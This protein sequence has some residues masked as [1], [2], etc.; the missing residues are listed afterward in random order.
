M[1]PSR[2]ASG[3][4]LGLSIVKEL[5]SVLG[6]AI[7]IRSAPDVGTVVDVTLPVEIAE[8]TQ[9]SPANLPAATKAKSRILKFP[10]QL[11][12]DS[13]CGRVLLVEDNELNAMLASR[14]L[15]A[16]GLEV[17]VAENGE[18]GFQEASRTTFDIVLMDCQMPVLDGYEATRQI[19]TLETRRRLARTPI[20]ALTANTLEGDREKCVR[21]GMDDYL[22][23]PYTEEQL[24]ELLV[25]W[26]DHAE[27]S[28]EVRRIP[29]ATL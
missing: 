15:E 10:R 11:A 22:G 23:K 1:G 7:N 25:R 13:L 3:T 29:D 20:I 14:T 26:L 24:R 17:V 16:F 28:R 5:V 6:G 18:V 4:G 12:S 2:R 9:N 27:T 19:R 8:T 21:A